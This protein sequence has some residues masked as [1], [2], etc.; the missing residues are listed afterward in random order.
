[1]ISWVVLA[2]I[3]AGILAVQADNLGIWK[4]KLHQGPRNVLGKVR[5]DV[6]YVR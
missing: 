1:M 5:I 4:K 3:L 2:V 6:G